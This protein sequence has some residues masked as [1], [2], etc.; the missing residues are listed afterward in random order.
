MK[1]SK[2]QA[3]IEVQGVVVEGIGESARFTCLSWVKEQFTSLLGIDPYPGTFNLE[4]KDLSNLEQWQK[5]KL[6]KGIE[7]IPGES[8]YCPAKGFPVLLNGK[9]KGALIIPLVPQYPE[10][11]MEV[12]ASQNIRNALSLKNGDLV[13]VK[14]FLGKK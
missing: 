5:M 8:G 12:I 2:N 7:I 9:M 6:Q 13:T 14:I 11:K 3:T 4:I 1:S 10:D